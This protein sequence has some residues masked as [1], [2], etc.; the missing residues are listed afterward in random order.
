MDGRG[1]AAPDRAEATPSGV[2][3]RNPV[4]ARL[5]VLRIALLLIAPAVILGGLEGALRLF[6]YGYATDFLV[7]AEGN[8]GYIPNEKFLY[9][10][11]PHRETTRGTPF[12]LSAEKPAGSYRVVILGESAALGTPNSSFGFGRILEAMLREQF[13]DRRVEIYNAALRGVNSHIILPIARECARFEPDLY[14]IYMGNNEMVGLHGARPKANLVDRHLGLIRF[15]HWVKGTRI[16][17]LASS[18]V[19]DKQPPKQD[20]AFFRAQ[21]IAL[22]DPRREPVY[23]HFRANLDDIVRTAVAAGARV[24]LCTVPSNL[25]DCPPVGSLDEPRCAE[26]QKAEW[27]TAYA[28]GVQ[29]L[30]QAQFDAAIG[31]LQRALAIDAHSA[32]LHYR[33]AQ[34]YLGSA[35]F[36]KAREQF[37]LA[38]DWDGMPLRVDTRLNEV[39]RDAA[40]RFAARGVVLADIEKLFESSTASEQGIPG[41]R[42]F[43]DHVHLRFAGDY[44]VAQA[45]YAAGFANP[46]ASLG[47]PSKPVLTLQE[48]AVQLGYN[49]WEDLEIQMAALQQWSRPP[50][51][52]CLDHPEI[53][54]RMER[55]AK[56]RQDRLGPADL[57]RVKSSYETALARRPD[58]WQLHLNY[59]LFLVTASDAASAIPHLEAPVRLFPGHTPFRIRLADA[60][61]H[62]GRHREAIEQL[63]EVLRREP[64]SKTASDGLEILR[65]TER[66]TPAR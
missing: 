48:C 63:R 32:N 51:L 4:S 61:A 47:S 38:R 37:R 65:R 1:A 36:D 2:G 17:Q 22:D 19:R 23:A 46:A 55:E 11:Y 56:R 53:S 28:A 57:R 25:A 5:W 20:M 10:F 16:G 13:P 45:L 43:S 50:F 27:E 30:K 35:Q 39:V 34:S 3:S 33:L 31:Q 7:R 66:R 24:L 8:A 29:A 40:K 42:L 12:L 64:Q 15:S 44:L 41:R 52:D 6:G 62:A 21:R 59:G 26:E 49:D 9:R 58:D 54:A 18:C 60:L 14:V